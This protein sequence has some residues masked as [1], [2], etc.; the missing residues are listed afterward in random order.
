MPG[1]GVHTV[2][3]ANEAAPMLLRSPRMLILLAVL[4]WSLLPARGELAGFDLIV[5]F[6]AI[7]H[8]G[9]KLSST[10]CAFSDADQRRRRS[11]PERTVT[12]A[13]GAH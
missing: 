7:G 12:V 4:Q 6:P 9:A 10:I 3:V 11:G 2:L 8:R 13:I 5:L 1:I